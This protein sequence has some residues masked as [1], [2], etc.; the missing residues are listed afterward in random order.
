MLLPHVNHIGLLEYHRA[1]EAINAGRT[2]VE[3]NA[4]TIRNALEF[5]TQ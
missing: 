3:H 5:H 1:A 4:E 2:C